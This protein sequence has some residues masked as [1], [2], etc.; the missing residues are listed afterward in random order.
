MHSLLA[1]QRAAFQEQCEHSHVQGKQP[2]AQT[3]IHMSLA[4]TQPPLHDNNT[5][6]LTPLSET[7]RDCNP[8]LS[9]LR[10][11]V[12][13]LNLPS[14]SHYHSQATGAASCSQRRAHGQKQDS[15]Y[16]FTAA[17]MY[18][19]H[20]QNREYLNVSLHHCG[21]PRPSARS[22]ASRRIRRVQRLRQTLARRRRTAENRTMAERPHVFHGKRAAYRVRNEGCNSARAQDARSRSRVRRM[23]PR[24]ARM[25]VRMCPAYTLPR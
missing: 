7:V 4:R 6:S 8:E 23:A 16:T 3:M 9:H 12:T 24:T 17:L 20:G 21:T 13:S 15:L 10:F 1:T 22:V 11:F 5:P 18:G 19:S 14:L 2:Q 25:F